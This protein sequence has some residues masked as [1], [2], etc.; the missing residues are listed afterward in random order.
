M[1]PDMEAFYRTDSLYVGRQ[2]SETATTCRHV[3]FALRFIIE[4]VHGFTAVEGQKIRMENGEV[5]WTPSRN[6]R[7]HGYERRAYDL[8]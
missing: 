8:A 5:I 3:V 4:G 7:D 1:S 2:S 6:L